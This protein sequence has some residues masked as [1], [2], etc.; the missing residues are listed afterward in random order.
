MGVKPTNYKKHLI[1]DIIAGITVSLILIPQSLA[2][3]QLAGLPAE[4]GLYAAIIPPILAAL[5]GS[6]RHLSTGPVAIISLMTSASISMYYAPASKDYISLAIFLAFCMGLIQIL[7][8]FIKLG[9]AVSLL[10]HPVLYGFTNAAALIIASTQLPKVLN[11][12]LTSHTHTY[13]MVLELIN[14]ARFQTDFSVLILGIWATI[15]IISFRIINKKIPAILIIAIISSLYAWLISYHGPVIGTVPTQIPLPTIPK[16]NPLMFIELLPNILIMSVIG[17]TE[18]ISVAQSIAI[19]TNTR[20]EPNKEL[21]GQGIANLI[22][23]FFHSYPVSGSIIR[24]AINF[25]SGA[26]TIVSSVVT[27]I[28]VLLTLLYLTRF[29]FYLPQVVLAAIIIVSAGSLIDIKKFLHILNTS[30]HDAVAALITFMATLYYAPHLDKGLAIGVIFS[31]AD[32]VYNNIHP[33][34]VFLSMYK[35]G[36]FHDVKRFNLARCKNIAVIRFDGQL[37]FA[38]SSYIENIIIN[39]LIK[40]SEITD[41]LLMANGINDIDST[42]ENMLFSL[43]KTLKRNGKTLHICSLKSQIIDVLDRSGLKSDIGNDNFL[44][45]LDEAIKHIIEVKEKLNTHTDSENCPLKQYIQA[46]DLAKDEV[47]INEKNSYFAPGYIFRKALLRA[48]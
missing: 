1:S 14:K 2:Y 35:D 7:F 44:T 21:R 10:S 20:I 15:A 42:G 26:K 45:R 5:F 6:S 8:S 39:D 43:W 32:Y 25:Q 17:F 30:K 3:A 29:L 36:W 9:S 12:T 47:I 37:F 18:S 16:I 13:Q 28:I 31:L 46:N 41:I 34:I 4:Y 19:K 40:N 48:R 38:N 24:T 11:I 23:S 27:G 22:G 33:R